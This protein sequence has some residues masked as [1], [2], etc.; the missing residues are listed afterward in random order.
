MAV[1]IDVLTEN[2][3]TTQE[4]KGTTVVD[5]VRTSESPMTTDGAKA[6]VDVINGTVVLNAVVSEIRPTVPYEGMVWID[7]S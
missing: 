1:V 6:V 4:V 2:A 7:V 3:T 5:V